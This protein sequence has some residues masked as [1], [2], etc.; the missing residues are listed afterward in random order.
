MESILYHL[1][2][3]YIQAMN[4]R[5]SETYLGTTVI[6]SNSPADNEIRSGNTKYF[7]AQADRIPD[8]SSIQ[9]IVLPLHI[10]ICHTC[11]IYDGDN[12]ILVFSRIRNALASTL[13]ILPSLLPSTSIL[14]H[15]AALNENDN[16]Q[17][18]SIPFIVILFASNVNCIFHPQRN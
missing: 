5:S 7:Y 11:S 14:L 16:V 10:C 2:H 1:S 13:C 3:I 4:E 8:H 17:L 18:F 6:S 9:N 15:S 12:S